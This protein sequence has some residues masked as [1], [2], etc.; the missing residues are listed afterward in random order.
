MLEMEM[1]RYHQKQQTG[2]S[3]QRQE[4]RQD[5]ASDKWQVTS[6]K[7]QRM[8]RSRLW[9]K[10]RCTST[11]GSGTDCPHGL[12]CCGYCFG[13]TA[14]PRLQTTQSVC[15]TSHIPL[16]PRL[17]VH[18]C[19]RMAVFVAVCLGLWAGCC[20]GGPPPRLPIDRMCVKWHAKPRGGG[21]GTDGK[22]TEGWLKAVRAQGRK[23]SKGHETRYKRHE[24]RDV[25]RRMWF[26]I[27]KML[28]LPCN[29][30]FCWG[31]FTGKSM[32]ACVHANFSAGTYRW[33]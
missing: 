32:S 6:Y 19:L 24:T 5:K 1:K 31:I 25:S 12:A 15:Q 21:L 20:C 29:R 27:G 11:S 8:I 2:E 7:W 33:T 30:A 9:T 4:T 23:Q 14:S 28:S 17:R 16:S 18:N 10:E 3:H 22:G 13:A 26:Q